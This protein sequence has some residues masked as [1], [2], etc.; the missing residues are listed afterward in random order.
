MFFKIVGY[1]DCDLY[2]LNLSAASFIFIC[3][4]LQ[5]AEIKARKESE[6]K[7]EARGYYYSFVDQMTNT[8]KQCHGLE[9]SSPSNGGNSGITGPVPWNVATPRA[10]H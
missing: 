8:L 1:L 7:V 5:L 2:F 3:T 9:C 10:V 6:G 4:G